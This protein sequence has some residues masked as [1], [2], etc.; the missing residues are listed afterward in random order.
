MKYYS[1]NN[2]HSSLLSPLWIAQQYKNKVN[3][4]VLN[5]TFVSHPSTTAL[6]WAAQNGSFCAGDL[7]LLETWTS[8][9]SGPR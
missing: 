8:I 2:T 9:T 1:C 6:V 5:L 4:T 7:V 3:D